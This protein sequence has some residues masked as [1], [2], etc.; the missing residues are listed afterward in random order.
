MFGEN[1]AKLVDENGQLINDSVI[2]E[3]SAELSTTVRNKFQSMMS[4]PL[5]TKWF[6]TPDEVA[7]ITVD[8]I[9]EEKPHFRYQTNKMFAAATEAKFTDPSGDSNIAAVNHRF[10][11][12]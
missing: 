6:Q 8:A 12:K 4:G 2:D 9:V 7:Q 10:F 3:K 5:A 1:R 11:A